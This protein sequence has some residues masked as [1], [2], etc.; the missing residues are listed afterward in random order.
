MRI[1]I[2][3]ANSVAGNCIPRTQRVWAQDFPLK[4]RLTSP[5]SDVMM[6]YMFA[7]AHRAAA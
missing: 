5:Q 2:H 4:A 1:I 6:Q 3:T 7:T